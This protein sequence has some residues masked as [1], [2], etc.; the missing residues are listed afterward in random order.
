MRL[1]L[2]ADVRLGTALSGGLDSSSIAALVNAELRRRG[3]NE[4]QE[5]FSSV[6]ADPA[7]RAHDESAFIER[8]ATQLDVRSNR[9]EPRAADVPTAHER[10]VWALD[11]PPANTLMASWHT[12][13]LV[14]RA[15]RGG[16]AGRAGRRRAARRL[17]RATCATGWCTRRSAAALGEA[18][19]TA[20]GMQG[21]GAH[22]AIGLAGMRCGASPGRAR[23]RRWCAGWAWAPTRR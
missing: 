12:F 18:R 2:R 20:A 6:Y 9:I 15:R 4:K 10:M 19:A 23:W 22:V 1:R 11:T 7:L 16:D 3:T 5:V 21:F 8:V 13:R 17:R 14:A